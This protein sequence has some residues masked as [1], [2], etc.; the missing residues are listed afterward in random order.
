[1]SDYQ[2]EQSIEFLTASDVT[3]LMKET[4]SSVSEIM[5]LPPTTL[6]LLLNFYKWDTAKMLE[7]FYT[8]GQ[9]LMFHRAGLKPISKEDKASIP[10]SECGICCLPS[11]DQVSL[12]CGHGFCLGCWEEYF[13]TQIVEQGVS[14]QM[15]CPG[16]GCHNYVED[17]FVEKIISNQAVLNKYWLLITDKFVAY[18]RHLAWCPS[19][20]CSKALKVEVSLVMAVECS[21]GCSFCFRCG[22]DD[23]DTVP[24]RLVDTWDKLAD[25]A[26][27][28]EEVLTR[29]CPGCGWTI[30]RDG[31]CNSMK[32]SKCKTEFCWWCLE[33]HNNHGMDVCS[34]HNVTETEAAI[35]ARRQGR[36]RFNALLRR[37]QVLE[38]AVGTCVLADKSHVPP[39]PKAGTPAGGERDRRMA[40]AIRLMEGNNNAEFLMRRVMDHD[41]DEMEEAFFEEMEGVR[42][43]RRMGLRVVQEELNTSNREKLLFKTVLEE[44]KS[45]LNIGWDVVNSVEK[46]YGSMIKAQ[47]TLVHMQVFANFLPPSPNNEVF[48]MNLEKLEEAVNRISVSLKMIQDEVKEN[49]SKEVLKEVD[50]QELGD[51]ARFCENRR[52]SLLELVKEGPGASGWIFTV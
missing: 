11:S 52:I 49:M 46:A 27:Y 50:K 15:E 37:K 43:R 19:P 40:V 21:C 42:M 12:T 17:Q 1:M 6:R 30:E 22:K 3:D 38:E 48:E 29:D 47:K 5:C 35:L 4:L 2:N 18:S 20:Q 32:C 26:N 24:C 51:S 34:K 31:G 7:I 23:H 10:S 41:Y 33:S 16:S 9:D 44:I 45:K 14:Q 39:F 13:N 25:N 28:F 36:Q 8:D